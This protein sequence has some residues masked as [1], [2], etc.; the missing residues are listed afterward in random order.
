M[1]MDFTTLN[2]DSDVEDDNVIKNLQNSP[3]KVT[4]LVGRFGKLGSVANRPGRGA[5][6]N[7]LTEDNVEIVRQS[8]TDDPSVLT[9]V[10][11]K[12]A[13]PKRHCVEFFSF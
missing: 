6:R 1:E 12:W 5:H 4:S 13:F 9:V 3:Y 2:P 8:V 11:A 7:I 10:P